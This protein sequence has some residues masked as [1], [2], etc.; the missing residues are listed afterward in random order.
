MY[1]LP[2]RKKNQDLNQYAEQLECATFEILEE[3]TC[4]LLGWD[5]KEVEKRRE[6][7]SSLTSTQLFDPNNEVIDNE[8]LNRVFYLICGSQV[9]IEDF[10][11]YCKKERTFSEIREAIRLFY[12]LMNA[13]GYHR[14]KI[15]KRT[16]FTYK[17]LYPT[18]DREFYRTIRSGFYDVDHICYASKC[19]YFVTCDW[20]LSAQATEIYRFLGC[21]TRVIYCKKKTADPSLPL[22]VLCKKTATS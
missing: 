14:N 2:V 5:T 19:D 6:E 4:E 8:S 16:K 10:K 1:A 17:A 12:K 22:A 20:T 21:K 7:I 18:Y 3:K 15:E 11:D 13:L 9:P